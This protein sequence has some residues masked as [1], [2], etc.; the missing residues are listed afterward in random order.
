MAA[1][2][3]L[4]RNTFVPSTFV[5]KRASKAG[6]SMSSDSRPWQGKT[7]R[8]DD[9]VPWQAEARSCRSGAPPEALVREQGGDAAQ[10]PAPDPA[11]TLVSGR[12][13]PE[14]DSLGG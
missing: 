8:P 13:V 4:R 6:V 5:A 12:D 14:P 10:P 7:E 9:A 11:E 3:L 2:I 1:N